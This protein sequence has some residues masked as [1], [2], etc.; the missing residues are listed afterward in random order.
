MK[1]SFLFLVVGVIVALAG[2]GTAWAE[3]SKAEKNLERESRRLNDTAAKPD[4][5]K[6][7]LKE[8]ETEFKVSNARVQALRERKLGYGE[9]A[10]VLSLTK[11]MPGG[12]TEE[13][14]Q[15]VLSMR[16]GPPVA[17]WSRVRPT[18]GGQTRGD[19]EPD[20]ENEQR[21][22]PRD[23]EGPRPVRH[24]RQESATGTATGKAAGNEG[25]R[26]AE[27]L[28]GRRQTHATRQRRDVADCISCG[29]PQ[30]A[31]SIWSGLDDKTESDKN[32]KSHIFSQRRRTRSENSM[33]IL[34]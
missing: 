16:Q 26:T 13:N 29:F 33:H 6:A 19:G 1:R 22:E 23:Q 20:Q 28:P 31:F 25:P 12:V 7:V 8:I 4:G 21:F 5:E 15:K 14:L 2:T 17:G 27:H 9:I 32:R 11:N 34:G 30:L 24:G 3:L 10:I 18:T